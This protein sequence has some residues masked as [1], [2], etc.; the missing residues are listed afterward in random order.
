MKKNAATVMASLLLF[1]T[2]CTS[3]AEPSAPAV[4][5]TH[6]TDCTEAVENENAAFSVLT[7]PKVGS[8]DLS[9]SQQ[10][11]VYFTVQLKKG[12]KVQ[13]SDFETLSGEL[14]LEPGKALE[15][16]LYN[17]EPRFLI[18]RLAWGTAAEP[19]VTNQYLVLNYVGKDS[20]CPL[21]TV[22]VK[23]NP[24]AN[25]KVRDLLNQKYSGIKSCPPNV[26]QM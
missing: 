14:P 18:F 1:L 23:K 5:Y 24:D 7:C 3:G 25:Q 2:A 19:F 13:S 12:E 10:S 21:A 9:I 17:G 15:W 4:A 6:L 11:P 22:D 8:Y 16:H 26:E 20:V